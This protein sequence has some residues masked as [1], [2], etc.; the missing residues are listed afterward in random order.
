MTPEKVIFEPPTAG[1]IDCP[2]FELH[3]L[4]FQLTTDLTSPLA[5]ALPGN[6]I[7]E[8]SR[9]IVANRT[10]LQL[11]ELQNATPCQSQISRKTAIMH[12]INSFKTRTYEYYHLEH[13][14][15][16]MHIATS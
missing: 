14:L 10:V 3:T 2:C 11:E 12:T 9:V 15:S 6:Q 16:G 5:F 8:H 1:H 7:S 13:S 4:G